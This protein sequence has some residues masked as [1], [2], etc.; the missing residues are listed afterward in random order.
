MDGFIGG[1]WWLWRFICLVLWGEVGVLLAFNLGYYFGIAN[2][3]VLIPVSLLLVFSLIWA[4]ILCRLLLLFPF[5][6]CQNGKC[7]DITDYEWPIGLIFGRV[8]WGVY[9]YRCRCGDEYIREGRVF[10]LLQ[11][12]GSKKPYMALTGF[13]K[14]TPTEDSY[15]E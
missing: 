4:F 2:L 7:H 5:P 12:D 3:W 14:W 15:K 8:K 1:I 13:R 10:Y 11:S 9:R 6:P